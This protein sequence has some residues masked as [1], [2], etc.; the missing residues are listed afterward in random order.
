MVVIS[1]SVFPFRFRNS[2]RMLGD[3]EV[4][5]K[6]ST[7]SMSVDLSIC[8]CEETLFILFLLSTDICDFDPSVS[9]SQ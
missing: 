9:L 4:I 2:C 1:H 7:E 5:P 6:C 8:W 3:L